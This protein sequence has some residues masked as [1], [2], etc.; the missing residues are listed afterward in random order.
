MLDASN[1]S[2]GAD[3]LNSTIQVA[4]AGLAGATAIVDTADHAVLHL[5]FDFACSA[6]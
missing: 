5:C 1:A 3:A 6:C 2:V 4:E